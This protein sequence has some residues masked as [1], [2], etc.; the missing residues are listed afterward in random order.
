M[1]FTKIKRIWPLRIA[2]GHNQ[3]V[4]ARGLVVPRPPDTLLALSVKQNRPR[5]ALITAGMSHVDENPGVA[6]ALPP[7]QRAG[8]IRYDIVYAYCQSKNKVVAQ[9]TKEQCRELAV[10][11]F[12]SF[13]RPAYTT[14]VDD[15]V[16]PD[17]G[18]GMGSSQMG[19][20]PNGLGAYAIQQ[21][22]ASME[23]KRQLGLLHE[24]FGLLY[25]D[26]YNSDIRFNAM[27]IDSGSN[28]FMSDE[29]CLEFMRTKSGSNKKTFTPFTAFGVEY[30]GELEFFH[31][32]LQ[33][34]YEGT[35][36]PGDVVG[37]IP[38]RL[39]IL[40]G[41]QRAFA[42]EKK[43]D[44][45]YYH[46]AAKRAKLLDRKIVCYTWTTYAEVDNAHVQLRSKVPGGYVQDRV[47]TPAAQTERLASCIAEILGTKTVYCQESTS[48]YG[49][50]FSVVSPR[51]TH[52]GVEQ[53]YFGTNQ[54]TF[55]NP[56]NDYAPGV[57]MPIPNFP[58]SDM[59]ILYDAS[60]MVSKARGW[61]GQNITV[62]Y[63]R[64]QSGG[65]TDLCTVLPGALHGFTRGK[66]KK[67]IAYVLEDLVRG[68]IGIFYHNFH[69]GPH[70]RERV[71]I[72]VAGVKEDLGIVEGGFPHAWNAKI[73]PSNV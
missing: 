56:G 8:T 29:A 53:G 20:V 3:T 4:V 22:E 7:N 64:V 50:D 70:E 49:E 51:S 38:C 55:A 17:G 67:G 69:L 35:A 61:V 24:Q 60:Y 71:Y 52:E 41:A 36:E 30:R 63:A 66:A 21:D 15:G 28:D 44:G 1:A 45:S 72:E 19:E 26:G 39:D 9:L 58:V 33:N 12:N 73:N 43:P 42:N 23:V 46:D 5:L 37:G 54:V 13:A 11:I 25:F 14:L 62:K 47:F 59:D 40:K 10:K 34:Y 6:S 32:C 16:N 57:P 2:Y 27:I 68:R 48:H 18:H 65:E 31:M